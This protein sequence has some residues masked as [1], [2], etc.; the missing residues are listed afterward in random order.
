MNPLITADELAELLAGP[1]PPVALDVRYQLG[2]P[3]WG[4]EQYKAGHLSGAHFID[5]ETELS[6]HHPQGLGG[7]HP[8]PSAAALQT[9]LRRC[10]VHDDSTVVVLD[11]GTMLAAGR[12]WWLLRHHG[13]SQGHES[14]RVLDGGMTAWLAAGGE[15]TTD[16]TPAGDGD[17]VLGPGRMPTVDADELPE[18][19]AQG[20]RLFD[21]RAAE[22]FRGEVEPID[23]VA[24]HI[25][26]ARNLPA[27]SLLADAGGFLPVAEL[28]CALAE[29][30][31]GDV[32]SCGSGLTASQVALACEAVGTAGVAIYPGSWSDWIIDPT[33]P[34]VT[35]TSG[36]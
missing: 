7:R 24:G 10:G 9:V 3:G 11:Q 1:T 35:S 23:P 34:V 2:Q 5:V 36:T 26:G 30:Q 12:L 28:R 16:P 19:L 22:R 6:A 32:L 15:V 29:V 21:V 27:A 8:L 4:R 14:V 18:A 25:P 13:S 33:R 31:P 17:V 20:H